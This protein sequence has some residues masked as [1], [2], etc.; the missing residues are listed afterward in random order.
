MFVLDADLVYSLAPIGNRFTK[1]SNTTATTTTNGPHEFSLSHRIQ[2]TAY[3]TRITHLHICRGYSYS[4]I[5]IRL[6]CVL[7][8]K[9]YANES[10]VKQ[11]EKANW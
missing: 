5:H 8:K 2:T 6:I 4:H 7:P 11:N 9:K 1:K 3:A 10:Y